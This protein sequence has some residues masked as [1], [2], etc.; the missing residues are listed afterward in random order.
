M[1]GPVLDTTLVLGSGN[2]L[3]TAIEALGHYY[4]TIITGSNTVYTQ[5]C[6]YIYMYIFF[7]KDTYL[8]P[9]HGLAVGWSQCWPLQPG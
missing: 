4:D 5:K 1:H 3:A 9:W 6:V 2:L 8:L 7:E